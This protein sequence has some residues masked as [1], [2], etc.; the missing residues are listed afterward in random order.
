[1][2]NYVVAIPTYNR[3]NVISDKTLKTLYEGKIHKNK[4]Y[5]FVANREQ[6]KLYEENVSKNLYNKMIIGKLGI[7]NQRIFISKYFP[8][9]QYII[10]MDDDIEEVSLLKGT[11][12]LVRIKDLNSFFL[13]AY[14]MLKEEGLY[15]W[16]IYPVR[17]PFFMK[18]KISYDLKFIIGVM[19][20]YI[21]RHDKHLYPSTKIETKEDYEMSILYYKKDGGVLRFNNINPKTKNNAEGGVGA[22][23]FERNK[24]SANY[25]QKTYPDLITI[26]H[27]NN[28]MTEVKLARRPRLE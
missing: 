12:K 22:D 6:Y 19:Y 27:R 23:R 10:S 25:L 16:G 26:F 7:T 9:N 1:M 17:N 15:I 21:N 14:K 8:E 2:S 24:V 18:K 13:E 4:I 28:G 11:D 20:G 5:L 3:Y